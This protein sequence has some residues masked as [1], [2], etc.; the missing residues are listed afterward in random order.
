MARNG[1]TQSWAGGSLAGVKHSPLW[2]DGFTGPQHPPVD[3]DLLVDL[4]V[5]GGGFTGLWAALQAAEQNPGRVVALVEAGSLGWAASGRNGGFCS[6]TLTHGLANGLARWPDEIGLLQRLGRENLDA[7]ERTVLA[8]GIDCG[9]TRAGEMVA[10]VE[11]WQV[12]ALSAQVDASRQLGGRVSMLDAVQAR[13]VAS[14]H[15]YLGGAVDPDSTAVLD[16]ARL[17]L[18]LAAAAV[19]LGVRVY[20][21]TRVVG[22]RDEGS[23][24]AVSVTTGLDTGLAAAPASTVVRNHTVR[25]SR[26]VLATNVFPSP[27]RRVRPFTVPVWDHVLATEPLSDRQWDDLGWH[28]GQGISDAGNQF[29]YYRTTPDRRVVWGGYDA[30]YYYGS[31]LTQRRM[32]HPETSKR[33][34]EHF[35][36]TFPQVRGLRFTHA[37]GGAI[38]TSTRFTALWKPALGRKVVSVNGYTGLGVGA[39]RFGASVALDLLEGVSNERTRLAMV[40]RPP[41]PFPP[42]PLRWAGIQLTRAS[43]GRADAT[44]GRRNAWL[45]LLDRMGMGFDS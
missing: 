28:G 12:D 43:L 1:Q 26:V 42:E 5:V 41:L 21:G 33:L 35:F 18:G 37:W 34:A 6:A 10:A 44:A 3:A 17:V 9:W 2:L 15:T 29:H 16:P 20:E 38:D 36:T 8:H 14:S 11:P 7:I 39:S 31:D 13:A 22:V 4:L 24:V 19:S 45:R 23:R 32:R 30:L 40:R 27:L 25:A